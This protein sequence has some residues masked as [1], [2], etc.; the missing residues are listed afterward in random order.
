[1]LK[2]LKPTIA[3]LDSGI[4]GISILQ[5]LIDK[6]KSGNYI[7]FADNLYMPYGNKHKRFLKKRV[8]AIIQKLIEKYNADM[9]IVACN[10]ASS[11]IDENKYKNVLTMRFNPNI[12]CFATKLTKKMLD[13]DNVIADATLATQI[14][15]NI[16][17][18]NKLDRLIKSHINK[19]KLNELDRFVLGCT[20]Y[21]LVIDIFKKYCPNTE[22]IKNSNYILKY[23]NYF[24]NTTDLT[25]LFLQSKN[26]ESYL[27][28]LNKLIRR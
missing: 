14:E 2:K 25:I 15:K 19:Y 22:I 11:L 26:S 17:D 27:N 8:E 18:K 9:V 4:G 13:R 3:I 7:Y 16:F 10:T 28:K 24:P 23:I 1:M 20:H 6:Y 5:S 12:H 21:E